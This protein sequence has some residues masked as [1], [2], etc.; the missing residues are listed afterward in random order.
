MAYL[1]NKVLILKKMFLK[2]DAKRPS[3]RYPII[4][5]SCK[6]QAGYIVKII[7]YLYISLKIEV[8]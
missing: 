1:E 8:C 3:I 4:I 6:N 2:I 5:C 7:E